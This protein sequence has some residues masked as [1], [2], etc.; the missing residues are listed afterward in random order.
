MTVYLGLLKTILSVLLIGVLFFLLL[1]IRKV[2]SSFT[3]LKETVDKSWGELEIS[4]KKRAHEVS[5]LVSL[6]DAYIKG[7]CA[8]LDKLKSFSRRYPLAPSR[9]EKINLNKQLPAI[10]NEFIQ[11]AQNYPEVKNHHYFNEIQNI[12]AHIASDIDKE[13]ITYNKH[14]EKINNKINK[15]PFNIVA[16]LL[17][18]KPY[19]YFTDPKDNQ[20]ITE[21][22]FN[23][24]L[25]PLE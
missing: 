12:I 25:P 11:E 18:I 23:F 7:T 8:S 4:L 15:F 9:K 2:Y 24:P 20:K 22:K 16:F 19:E 3:Y 21:V 1:F 17:N 14:A 6:A 10:I 5:R 13:R